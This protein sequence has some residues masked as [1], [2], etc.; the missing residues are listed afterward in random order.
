MMQTNPATIFD[1]ESGKFSSN[2]FEWIETFLL[3][4]VFVILLSSFIFRF[5]VVDGISMV[6]TFTDQDRVISS[7]LFYTP[8]TGDVVVIMNPEDPRCL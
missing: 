2:T 3:P 1:T 5:V 8:K 4:A 7:Q 6:P